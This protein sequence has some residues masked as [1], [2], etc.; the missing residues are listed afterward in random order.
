MSAKE[1]QTTDP[2]SRVS[3]EMGAG[4]SLLKQNMTTFG[5]RFKNL[6]LMLPLWIS[7]SSKNLMQGCDGNNSQLL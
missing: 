1:I 5:L 2:L 7:V 4:N 3:R 6:I